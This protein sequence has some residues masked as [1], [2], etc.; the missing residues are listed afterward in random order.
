MTLL[1]L[2]NKN[3]SLPQDSLELNG[4]SALTR[5]VYLNSH[6]FRSVGLLN[7]VECMG[8]FIVIFGGLLYNKAIRINCPDWASL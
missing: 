3:P 1:R 2:L 6:N 8:I 7:S 5:E 4:L